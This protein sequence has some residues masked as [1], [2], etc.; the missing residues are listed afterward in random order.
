MAKK[1]TGTRSA[2]NNTQKPK[3]EVSV[4]TPLFV[5]EKTDEGLNEYLAEAKEESKTSQRTN[6]GK[7]TAKKAMNKDENVVSEETLKEIEVTM[8]EHLYNKGKEQEIEEDEDLSSKVF[9]TKAVP[10]ANRKK[11]A[12]SASEIKKSKVLSEKEERR[13]RKEAKKAE[14][15]KTTFKHKL[16]V[17]GVL[18]VLGIFTGSGLGVWYFNYNLKS[19]VDYSQAGNPEDYI[20]SIDDTLTRNFEGIDL[21]DAV[22]WVSYAQGMGKTPADL[23]PVDNFVLAQYNIANANSYSVIGTGNISANTF[24]LVVDQFMYSEKKFDGEKYSFVSISPDTTGMVGDVAVCDVLAKG[25]NSIKSYKGEILE[26]NR[27]ADWAYN[28]TYSTDEHS[29]LNGVRV[30]DIQPYLICEETVVSSSEITVDGDG[31]YVF[32]LQLDTIKAVL[33]Y[34]KQVQ[35]TGG[36]SSYPEFKSLQTT[37]TITPDWQLVKMDIVEV[38]K[39]VKIGVS[40]T[41]TGTINIDFT[42]NEPVE[43]PA[44]PEIA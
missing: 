5:E 9:V 27:S 14:Y 33:N 36:L 18:S 7:S 28:N 2:L 25:G 40:P 15:K 8:A 3:R 41:I 12:S 39:A 4:W 31:N 19:N 11:D 16:K 43:L 34:I 26:G 21:S 24:G 37:F 10:L 23:S 22:N 6:T 38:Y 44:L 20:Q 35:R 29:V 42:V 13:A 30:N 1:R 32:T 17:I